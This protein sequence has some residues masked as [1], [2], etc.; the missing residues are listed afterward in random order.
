MLETSRAVV[1]H[2]FNPS[3]WEAEV[4]QFLSSRSAWSTEFVPGQPGLYRETVP[5]KTKNKQNNNNKQ[6][7]KTNKQR[8]KQIN[9]K[10]TIYYKLSLSNKNVT[11][12][13]TLLSL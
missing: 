8:K 13:R 3:T 7:T 9:I 4:G 6:K 5:G 12:E 11:G 2:A 1:A 10:L